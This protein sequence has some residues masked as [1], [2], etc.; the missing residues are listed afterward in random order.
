MDRQ[1]YNSCMVPFMK[2]GGEDRKLRFCIGAKVCSGKSKTEE[3][4]RQICL[5][6]PPKEAK[7]R[8]RKTGAHCA[9]DM[10]T[11]ANCVITTISPQQLTPENFQRV[12]TETLQQC[13]CGK[14]TKPT[15]ME[16]AMEHIT[17]EHMEALSVVGKITS[18][19]GNET[20]QRLHQGHRSQ[21][22]GPSGGSP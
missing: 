1:K 9:Q 14:V 7:P 8:K 20:T 19:L 11:L 21:Q 3:E 2:G 4:A 13:G 16:K 5:T 18:G 10:V 22:T 17:P 6:Q 12:L 15:R